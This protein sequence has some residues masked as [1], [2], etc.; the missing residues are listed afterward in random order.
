MLGEAAM[1]SRNLRELCE[2]AQRGIGRVVDTSWEMAT[3]E[4]LRFDEVEGERS[5]KR[6][7][8]QWYTGK[9]MRA[10]NRTI[11]THQ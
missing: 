2:R 4:D 3:S 7:L 9:V 6:R 11:E 10:T 5:W 1:T 8:T